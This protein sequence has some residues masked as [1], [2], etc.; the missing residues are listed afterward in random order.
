LELSLVPSTHTP[1]MAGLEYLSPEGLRVDGRRPPELRK[2]QCRLGVSRQADGS[3]YLEQ[4]NTKVLAT[5][6]G[7]HDVSRKSQALHD[8]A[9]INCQF[10]MATF[11]TSE[12]RKRTRGDRKSVE[13]SLAL[14]QMF[15][16]VILRELYPQSKIDIYVQVLQSDGGNRCVSINAAT[17]ALIDAGIPLKD[18]VCACSAGFIEDT[19]LLDLNYLEETAGGPNLTLALLPKS[20]KIVLVQMDSRLHADHLEK[21]MNTAITGISRVHAILDRTVKEHLQKTITA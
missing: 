19:P 1:E 16:S 8:K 3:A 9:L 6:Y 4:G 7:P 15:E 20:N 21:V 5:V 10:S 13:M 17:M 14:R 2:L 18:F 11:S 12:R